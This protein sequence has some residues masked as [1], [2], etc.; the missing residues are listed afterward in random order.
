MSPP[1]TA[2]L[3]W[4]RGKG[5]MGRDTHDMVE[6]TKQLVSILPPC[7]WTQSVSTA[8]C[9]YFSKE[10]RGLRDMPWKRS[11]NR[12]KSRHCIDYHPR[13]SDVLNSSSRIFHR[14][15]FDIDNSVIHFNSSGSKHSL[16]SRSCLIQ[17]ITTWY[18]SSSSNTSISSMQISSLTVF[19]KFN[20]IYRLY[21]PRVLRPKF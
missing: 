10:K 20:I 11:G 2:A 5:I 6:G 13:A 15:C 9:S 7:P 16:D 8:T 1:H 19:N 18:T 4:V 17:A 3:W 14:L 21:R 12:N